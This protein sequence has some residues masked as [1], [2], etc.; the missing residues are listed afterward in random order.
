MAYFS[1]T[2][3]SAKDGFI[4]SVKGVTCTNQ[5][6]LIF[7]PEMKSI[8]KGK[9]TLILD[10]IWNQSSS[11]CA[12]YKAVNITIQSP[13][14]V[15]IQ[16][17]KIGFSDGISCLSKA[18]TVD[19]KKQPILTKKFEADEDYD[20]SYLVSAFVEESFVSYVCVHN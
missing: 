2:L 12:A 1:L 20:Q 4:H 19:V 5:L 11:I 8:A 9:Y 7:T 18:I 14:S 10:A 15:E 17:K 13:S 16:A 3:L 6:S